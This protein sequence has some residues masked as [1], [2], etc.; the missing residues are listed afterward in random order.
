MRSGY[1]PWHV[2]AGTE[3]AVVDDVEHVCASK[4]LKRDHRRSAQATGWGVTVEDRA[5]DRRAEPVRFVFAGVGLVEALDEQQIGELFHDL[6]R[7]GDAARPEASQT[8]S[9]FDFSSPV[10]VIDPP[11]LTVFVR[12]DTMP[13]VGPVPAAQRRQVRNDSGQCRDR[14]C[15][16]EAAA[17]SAQASTSVQS[18]M[19]ADRRRRWVLGSR[20]SAFARHGRLGGG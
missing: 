6:K 7:V 8:L 2:R 12:R 1:C 13:P 14:C 4:S 18:Q 17:C 19:S 5:F 15:L 16:A 10:I 3:D 20:R 9:I 11:R